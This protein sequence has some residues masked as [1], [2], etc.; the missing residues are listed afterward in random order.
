MTQDSQ[1]LLTE[2]RSRRNGGIARRLAESLDWSHDRE[3]GVLGTKRP[4]RGY[5]DAY[6]VDRAAAPLV[7]DGLVDEIPGKAGLRYRCAA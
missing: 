1:D 6:R 5:W 3:G 4:A 7:S 2:L